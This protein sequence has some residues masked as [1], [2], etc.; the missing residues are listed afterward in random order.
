M[1]DISEIKDEL[2]TELWIPIAKKGGSMFYPRL[3]INK[4]MKVLTLT[5]HMNCRELEEFIKNKLTKKDLIV[6][7][8]RATNESIRLEVEKMESCV[9]SYVYEDTIQ[10]NE[11]VIQDKFPFDILNL[12]FSSQKP[13]IEEGRIEKE[14]LG[15]EHTLRIQ[16]NNGNKGMV[17]IYTTILNS[18]PLSPLGIKQCSDDISCR[19]WN[20]LSIDSPQENILDKEQ[21]IECLKKILEQL[22][23]KYQYSLED[24][25]SVCCKPLANGSKCILSIG[26]ILKRCG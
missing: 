24:N 11:S 17:L 13:E 18:K 2:I 9:G 5:Q 6:G 21:K 16:S 14:V 23:L 20:G 3:K 22:P 4:K 26:I 8:N 12:D 15:I 25:L 10:D 7:W 19:G 1:T